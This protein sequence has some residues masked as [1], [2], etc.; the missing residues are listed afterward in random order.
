MFIAQHLKK[1]MEYKTDF[2]IGLFGFLFFQAT[3][4]IFIDLIFHAIPTLNGWNFEQML[5]I[6]GFAQIP[7]GI[8]HLLTDNLW[9]LSQRMVRTGQFDRYLLRPIPPLFHLIA[10]LLQTDAIGEL[11]VGIGLVVYASVKLAIRFTLL[12]WVFLVVAIAAGS[13]IYFSVK[14]VTAS[15]AFWTKR[16]QPVVHILYTFSD[17]A[18]YPISIYSKAIRI[19]ITYIV[20]FAFT[21]FI[22]AAYLV[23]R[24]NFAFALV[25]MVTAAAVLLTAGLFVWNRGLKVY[26]S[27][28]N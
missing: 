3:G 20:P 8:D 26:E 1:M 6:Y 5:F 10:E 11:I 28:G 24:Q 18:K 22:P 23:T 17:F 9:M 25:G 2:I 14:L 4:V 27:S 15:I 13:V 12:D 7:R 21:A 19:L 16:S